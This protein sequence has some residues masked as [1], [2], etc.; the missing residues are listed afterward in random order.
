MLE[1]K[2]R[3]TKLSLDFFPEISAVI[4]AV[5]NPIPLA[6][7]TSYKRCRVEQDPILA[8]QNIS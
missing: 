6:G 8:K 7:R 4:G 5:T 3:E 1:K 2:K